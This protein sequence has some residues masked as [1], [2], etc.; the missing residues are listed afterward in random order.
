MKLTLCPKE[1]ETIHVSDLSGD[2][3]IVAKNR[4]VLVA[5]SRN[6]RWMWID[7][8]EGIYEHKFYTSVED[9]VQYLI[10]ECDLLENDFDVYVDMEEAIQAV[11]Y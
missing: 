6:V 3:I 4:L 1:E 7:L 10:K 5:E 8:K 2:E 9:A 11:T